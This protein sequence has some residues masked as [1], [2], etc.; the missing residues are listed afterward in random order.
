MMRVDGRG[1]GDDRGDGGV[2][3]G[4]LA[5]RAF[6]AGRS[7]C[8][9]WCSPCRAPAS[10]RG[11]ARSGRGSRRPPGS[12][13]RSSVRSWPSCRVL[14]A[15]GGRSVHE[16]PGTWPG[17]GVPLGLRPEEMVHTAEQPETAEPRPQQRG[18]RHGWADATA[19][20]C[21]GRGRCPG[22][23]IVTDTVARADHP[24]AAARRR[25]VVRR[26]LTGAARRPRRPNPPGRRACDPRHAARGW[27]CAR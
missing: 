20:R 13:H 22:A 9:P 25:R 18:P 21:H 12:S 27:W 7:L 17:Q 14:F 5:R 4:G 16:A 23:G 15:P 19:A 24:H 8:G 10:R 2:L 1:R 11:S 3:P 6:G 26:G